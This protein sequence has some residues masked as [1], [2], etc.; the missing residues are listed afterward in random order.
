MQPF[1]IKTV[2]QGANQVQFVDPFDAEVIKLV[3]GRRPYWL[4]VPLVWDAPRTLGQGITPV[5][6]ER[7][8]DLLI[9]GARSALDYSLIKMRND[10]T[11]DYYSNEFVPIFC[12]TGGAASNRMAYQWESWIYLPSQT[13]LVIEAQLG[14]TTPGSGVLEPNG[15]I[16]FNCV[17]INANA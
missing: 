11:D 2:G 6:Q 10:T 17:V 9:T 7:R 8:F 12:V 16:V 14:E 1:G 5:S 3:K 15:E 4:S 13:R